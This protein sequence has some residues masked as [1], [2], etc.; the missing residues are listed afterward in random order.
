M[1]TES[2]PGPSDPPRHCY[3]WRW[4][5]SVFVNTVISGPVLVI[6]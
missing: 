4:E 6:N 3:S 2:P 5:M 1:L